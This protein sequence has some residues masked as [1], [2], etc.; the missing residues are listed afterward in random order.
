MVRVRV[1][2]VARV[3]VSKLL[4]LNFDPNPKCNFALTLIIYD[5]KLTL[6]LI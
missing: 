3:R 4:G 2:F 6:T 1:N 5:P